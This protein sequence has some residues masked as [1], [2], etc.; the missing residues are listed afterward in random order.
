MSVGSRLQEERRRLGLGREEFAQRAG[1][2]L[3]SLANYERD[4]R[5][6]SAVQ[7]LILHDIGVDIAYA[8]IGVRWRANHGPEE[9]ELIDRFHRL[10]PAQRPIVMAL[11][12]QLNGDA[13]DLRDIVPKAQ[14][15]HET[16]R[17]FRASPEDQK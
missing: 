14:T 7:L 1:M 17:P 2:H 5:S 12:A 16:P 6:L 10:T 13:I 8:L 3:N 15:L 9:Q 4:E 11:L